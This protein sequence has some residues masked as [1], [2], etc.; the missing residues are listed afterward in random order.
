MILLLFRY[1]SDSEPSSMV[2]IDNEETKKYV[3]NPFEANILD[4]GHWVDT[5]VDDFSDVM[6]DELSIIYEEDAAMNSLTLDAVEPNQHMDKKDKETSDAFDADDLSQTNNEQA[7]VADQLEAMKSNNEALSPYCGSP[8]EPIDDACMDA[9]DGKSQEVAEATITWKGFAKT[10]EVA[11]EFSNWTPLSL[12]NQEDDI[13]KIFLKLPKGDF[14]MRY[15]VDGAHITDEVTPSRRGPDGQLYNLL[16]V[17]NE[18]LQQDFVFTANKSS[19]IESLTADSMKDSGYDQSFEERKLC[20]TSPSFSIEND[21]E[22]QM[23]ESSSNESSLLHDINDISAEESCIP[24][25]RAESIQLSVFCGEADNL[26]SIEVQNSQ[27]SEEH[28]SAENS[29]PLV[30]SIDEQ[31]SVFCGTSAPHDHDYEHDIRQ[32]VVQ[33][34]EE[35]LKEEFMDKIAEVRVAELGD[36]EMFTKINSKLEVVEKKEDIDEAELQE[37]KIF[38]EKAKLESVA[39]KN[40]ELIFEEVRKAELEANLINREVE[41]SIAEERSLPDLKIKEDFESVEEPKVAES[42]RKEEVKNIDVVN[43]AILVS[44]EEPTTTDEGKDAVSKIKSEGKNIEELKAAELG[45]KEEE[46]KENLVDGSNIVEDISDKFYVSEEDILR[47]KQRMDEISIRN[48]EK[49]FTEVRNAELAISDKITGKEENKAQR[50]EQEKDAEEAR[51][52]ELKKKDDERLTEESILAELKRQEEARVADEAKIAEDARLDELKRQEEERLAEEARVAELKRQEEER[53]AE[54]KRLAELKR[55]EEER[56][57][58]EKRLA[59]LKRQE[60]ERLAEEARVAELKRQEEDRL[61]EEARVADLRRQEKERLAEEA[62]LAKIKSQEDNRLAAN[63]LLAE[64]RKKEEERLAEET[65]F[66]NIQNIEDEKKDLDAKINQEE[67]ERSLQMEIVAEHIRIAEKYR[68]IEDE[69]LQA[70][71]V[72]TNVSNILQG[73]VNNG[74]DTTDDNVPEI[75][76]D[77]PKKT[78]IVLEIENHNEPKHDMLVSGINVAETNVANLEEAL[79]VQE[80]LEDVENGP[81]SLESVQKKPIME[82]ICGLCSIM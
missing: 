25:T 31:L 52:A 4:A 7:F 2:I 53:L 15:I 57:A 1:D 80:S 48:T 64:I 74:F 39:K 10:V 20:S 19:P 28:F 13:W 81:S 50:E 73:N 17:R 16:Q 41:M 61:A 82:K 34:A 75:I 60:E 11:G 58:E 70:Q 77:Q 71:A 59:E 5:G 45:F 29:I 14:L 27:Q 63:S 72:Q 47:D 62:R 69:S 51:L 68:S 44:K 3:F 49:I 12:S 26:G 9:N 40:N 43:E 32:L 21:N 54:E 24:H 18:N 37:D 65:K 46:L 76:T 33:I 66:V 35:S 42:N 67:K 78:S 38:A 36:D 55:K 56:L 79:H 6:P 30:R 23:L 8:D 22:S